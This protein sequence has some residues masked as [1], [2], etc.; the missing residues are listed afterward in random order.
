VFDNSLGQ[1]ILD[2]LSKLLSQIRIIHSF[3]EVEPL[4][5]WFYSDKQL[6][7]RELVFF[8]IVPAAVSS[9]YR[10]LDPQKKNDVQSLKKLMAEL[11]SNDIEIPDSLTDKIELLRNSD[12][13]KRIL[14]HRHQSTA[15]RSERSPPRTQLEKDGK[16]ISLT[17]KD[18]TKTL[19]EVANV[20]RDILHVGS[21]YS[22][23][24][25]GFNFQDVRTVRTVLRIY[26]AAKPPTGEAW[27][28]AV[29]TPVFDL[30]VTPKK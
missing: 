2:D 20:T 25:A 15:H 16:S 29:R 4:S 8:S 30:T 11:T 27:E 7:V 23:L 3:G 14:V 22:S 19:I 5:S 17:L 1:A 21:A 10:I 18:A 28:K 13:L 24:P 26:G 6:D 12:D 9:A